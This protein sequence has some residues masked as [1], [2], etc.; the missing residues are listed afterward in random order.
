M[1]SKNLDPGPL[2]GARPSVEEKPHHP[3]VSFAIPVCN[4]ERF[5]GRALDSLLAQE[6]NDFEVVVCDN[7]STDGTQ[8]LMLRYSQGDRRVRYIRNEEN[9]GQIE[10]F[11]RVCELARGDFVRWMGADDW[12]EPDYAAKCVA[13]LDARPNA[14]GVTTQWR[15]LDDAGE[16]EFLDVPGPRVDAATPLGRLHITLRLLQNGELLF[17]PIYS[18][19]RRNALERSAMLPVNRWTDRLLA[20]ELCLMGPFCHL[21][22]FLATRRNAREPRKV[23]IER[24]HKRY[25]GWKKHDHRWMLY[26]NYAKIVGHAPLMI[27]QKLGCWGIIFY[28]WLRDE[29]RRRWRR[30]RRRMASP[31]S[32]TAGPTA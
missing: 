10:N 20:F 12:L 7:A 24:W 21:D 11:N 3:R 6:F 5:L 22:D 28:Y 14:V 4:A 2:N 30:L 18:L 23:R 27:R 32:K 19:I 17:D 26:L 13:A 9:I 1:E 15:Y 25:E 31:G 8:D 29:T 16:V